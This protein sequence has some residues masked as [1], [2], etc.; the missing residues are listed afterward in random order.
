MKK[1]F[2][3]LSVIG[4]T[5]IGAIVSSC[6]VED[7]NT[8]FVPKN[9]VAEILVTTFDVSTGTDI[10]GKT[11]LV[12]SASSTA[13]NPISISGNLLKIEGGPSI[14]EQ[15][16]TITAEYKGQTGST[17]VKINSLRAGGNASYGANI[18]VGSLKLDAVAI[19]QI[20][21]WDNKSEKDVTAYSTFSHNYSGNYE[22]VDGSTRGSYVI[23]GKDGIAAFEF[24]VTA[25]YGDV[26]ETATVKIGNIGAGEVRNYLVPIA[27]GEAVE[28]N[29]AI[30]KITVNVFDDLLEKDVTSVSE[31]SAELAPASS[32]DIEVND[33]VVTISAGKSLEIVAQDVTIKVKYGELSETSIVTLDKIPENVVV[34][35]SIN[36]AFNKSEYIRKE[37]ESK[38]TVD[39]GTFFSTHN[40]HTYTHEYGHGYGHGHDSGEWLYNETEFILETTINYTNAYG[41]S[42]L[43]IVYLTDIANDKKAVD[44]YAEGYAKNYVE[45]EEVLNI[46]VSA[47][48]RYSAYAT[49]TTTVTKYDVIRLMNETEE[50]VG[51]FTV[52]SIATQAE[53][54]EA[55]MPGHEGHYIHGHGHADEHGYSSNAGGGIVWA[56]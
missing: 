2:K 37:V 36:V 38:S 26:S 52:K 8:T 12:L 39:V 47:F 20:S 55:A 30:A 15:T 14:Q 16:V 6:Q 34:E 49:R 40:L 29:P 1:F 53:Y 25:K 56:D 31:I 46:Q 10:T 4:M 50:V 44:K 27:V 17:T 24:D 21:V 22:I 32:A 13:N 41:I 43:S 9:A 28:T 23:T 35:K 7:I 42:D 5:V 45:E 18:E 19:V 51:S 48:A 11:D 3:M 33:N 54:C